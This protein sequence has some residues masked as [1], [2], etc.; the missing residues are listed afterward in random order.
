M[1]AVRQGQIKPHVL[2]GV[3]SCLGFD[4]LVPETARFARGV[5]KALRLWLLFG[6]HDQNAAA[7]NSKLSPAVMVAELMVQTTEPL[8]VAVGAVYEVL[9]CVMFAGWVRSTT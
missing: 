8:A 9:A 3:G 1:Y 2:G 7:V 4:R 5:G 6:S